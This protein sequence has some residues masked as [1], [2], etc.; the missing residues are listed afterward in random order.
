M[1]FFAFKYHKYFSC[2]LAIIEEERLKMLQEHAANILGYLPRG[3]LKE[4]DLAVIA[5]AQS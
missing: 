5:G 2:R 1:F 4:D 3:L